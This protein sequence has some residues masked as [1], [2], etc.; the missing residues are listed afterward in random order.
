VLPRVHALHDS[1]VGR[2]ALGDWHQTINQ[3]AKLLN[4]GIDRVSDL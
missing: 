2:H 3:A 4:D 1:E